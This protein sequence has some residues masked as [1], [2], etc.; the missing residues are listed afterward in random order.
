MVDDSDVIT[1]PT[2]YEVVTG[3]SVTT[4]DLTAVILCVMP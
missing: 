4:A 2:Q 1:N 3:G